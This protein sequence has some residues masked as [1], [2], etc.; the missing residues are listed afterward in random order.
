MV[1]TANWGI[2]CYLPP[3]RGTRNNHWNIIPYSP[4]SFVLFELSVIRWKHA[5]YQRH[6]RRTFYHEISSK[7]VPSSKMRSKPTNMVGSWL[8][9]PELSPKGVYRFTLSHVTMNSCTK[10]PCGWHVAGFFERLLGIPLQRAMGQRR[11]FTRRLGRRKKRSFNV[12]FFRSL[13]CSA[14]WVRSRSV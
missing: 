5:K 11:Q 7:L 4:G 2:I 1:Y 6:D 13:C 12:S 10:P 9:T 14:V 8:V 3:F